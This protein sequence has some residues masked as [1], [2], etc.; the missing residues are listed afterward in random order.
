MI[1]TFQICEKIGK[2]LR[3]KEKK[4]WVSTSYLIT[5]MLQIKQYLKC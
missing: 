2:L 4:I 1:K 5:R 3:K